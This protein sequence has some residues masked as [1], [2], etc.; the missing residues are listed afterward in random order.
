MFHQAQA[1]DYIDLIQDLEAL[2]A[3]SHVDSLAINVA[4]TGWAVGDLFDINGGTV[5]AGLNATGE[6]LVEAGGIPSSIR[7]FNG[8]AYS[9]NPGVAATTT[10]L[11]AST[12]INLTVDTTILST[13]WTVDRSALVGGGPERELLVRGDGSGSDEI[14]IGFQTNRDG[15][16]GTFS[17]EL[18]G[19][20]GFST[21][22]PFELQPGSSKAIPA[23]DALYTPL[24][25]G[26]IDYWFV[27]DSFHVKGIFKSGS[28]YTNIYAGFINT[29]A[30]PAEYPYPLMILGCSTV[31]TNPFGTSG[32][33]LSGMVDPIA[34][35]TDESGPG[36]IREVDGQWYVMQNSTTNGTSSR[37]QERERVI[38][39]MGTLN[40]NDTDVATINRF[41]F[42]NEGNQGA[43][44]I[45]PQ[46]GLSAPGHRLQPTPDSGG[47]IQFLLPTV[48]YQMRPSQVFLGELIDVHPVYTIGIGAVSEDT[49]TD[50]N[51]DV[52]IIFQ[53][54]N[55]TDVW[56]FFAIKRT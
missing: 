15:G 2:M 3:N 19:N 33:S 50:A 28:S 26:I 23:T 11:G 40:P 37:S 30:T 12:G 41:N 14:F 17:W 44:A 8:G 34:L 7:I 53:Q 25:N 32:F 35:T 13:G 6:I 16:S 31:R 42:I 5:I 38:W 49:L 48:I 1:T 27:I 4:G 55:R 52:Y 45:F 46:S 47:D 36:A 24:N 43:G 56:A 9:V 29:F 18:I 54:C 20:T 21:G 22:D 10:A 51:G 39:P